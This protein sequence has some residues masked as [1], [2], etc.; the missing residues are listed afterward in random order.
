MSRLGN[1]RGG[2]RTSS[3]KKRQG[4][5]GGLGGTKGT[6]ESLYHKLGHYVGMVEKVEADERATDGKPFIAIRVNVLHAHEDGEQFQ[7]PGSGTGDDNP[8]TFL[9]HHKPGESPAQILLEDQFGY[10]ENWKNFL[11]AAAGIS[12]ADAA[13]L[14][15][16]L[17]AAVQAE[18]DLEK[19]DDFADYAEFANDI[20]S[21]EDALDVIW[22]VS[23]EQAI[24][25]DQPLAGS[26]IE[27]VSTMRLKKDSRK[28]DPKT[29]TLQD[30]YYTRTVYR[31]QVSAADVAEL[32]DEDILKRFIPNID[33]RVA[34]EAEA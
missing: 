25:D 15:G 12:D 4:R 1:K 16:R 24:G 27:W 14:A 11:E 20:E 19:N 23:S 31:C 34:A 22:E 28:K 3:K 13:E 26:L 7:M 5:F 21:L 29:L 8:P 2:S 32:V 33:D 9:Q 17:F 6:Q 30:D 18:E 10:A